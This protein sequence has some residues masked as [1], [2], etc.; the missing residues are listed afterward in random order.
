MFSH[1]NFTVFMIIMRIGK[2][3]IPLWFRCFK[4]NAPSNA[5]AESLIKDGI[6]Y[7]SNLFSTDFDLIFLA[8]RCF[9]S[10]N[11]LKH[12]NKFMMNNI[13]LILLFLN[14]IM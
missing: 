6:S 3:G 13:R 14:T 10:S 7:V 8:D 11:L 5:M 12:T 2:H 1:N 9:N 4:G